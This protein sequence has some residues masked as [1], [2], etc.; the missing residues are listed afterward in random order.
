M[1]TPE[2]ATLAKAI[3]DALAQETLCAAFQITAAANADRPALTTFGS[4]DTITWRGYADRVRS[5]ATGLVAQG[6]EAGDPVAIMLTTRPEFNL[7]DTALLHISG[8]P[9]SIYF[10]NPVEQIV[11][12]MRNAT[13][14]L[15][16]TEPQFVGLLRE[17]RSR[18]GYPE[19]IVVTDAERGEAD[20]TLAELE[21]QDA[22][23]GFDFDAA[24]RAVTAD[25]L[26]AIVYTSGTTGEP[27]GVQWS[28]GALL[29]HVRAVHGLCPASPG[30]RIVAYL[31]M[32]HLFERWFSHYGSLGLGYS[33][34]CVP[35]PKQL[36]AALP[37]V[38]PT[39]FI[40]VP[41]IYEKL[42]YAMK[43]MAEADPVTRQA[44]EDAMAYSAAKL[45]ESREVD[46]ETRAKGEAATE[47][48]APIRDRLGFTDTE[49]F[50]SASAP[51]RVDILQIFEAFGC[52]IAEIWGMSETAMSLS[53]P[54]DRIKIGTVG[55]P[56]PGVEAKLADDGELLI[57]GGIF[58]G[59]RND[60]ERTREAVD[61]DGWMHSGDI[62]TVD[63]D[64]YYRIVD[65]K[66]EIIINAAGKNIP[67]AMVEL[68]IKQQCSLVGYVTAIGDRR[69]YLTALIVLDE[70]ALQS[71]ASANGLSGSFAEL[72]QHPAVHEEVQR[73]VDAANATL[74]R[75]EQVKRFRILDTPWMPGGDEVTQTMKVKRRVVDEKYADVIED[76]YA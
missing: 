68:R 36:A 32:A 16:V 34:T 76:L 74:A 5:I 10:T 30:G 73:G 35:D 67:P 56:L 58:S 65:R 17:V 22:P 52:R 8:I 19:R 12:Q 46:P 23:E 54:M 21:A 43:G 62:A 9:F 25:T 31:P 15:A 70:E 57:R 42:A 55:K 63:E 33:I 20:M 66:K 53:N 50:G 1:A 2:D 51:A 47:A 38:R 39:R 61:E 6:I 24:W 75:I 41:R 44:F 49:Y 28:H 71:F 11:P 40:A 13:P 4:D 59:Y 60:P 64:G 37:Q 3:E 45:D 14:K 27:K 72:S 18:C 48:L 69:P 26:A 29:S 7:V